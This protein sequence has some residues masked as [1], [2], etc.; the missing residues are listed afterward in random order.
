LALLLSLLLVNG[1]SATSRRQATTPAPAHCPSRFRVGF[2]TDVAGLN[3][4]VDAEG[5]AGTQGA[6]GRRACLQVELL[7]PSDPGSYQAALEL[8][9]DRDDLVI[10]GSF[11]LTDAVTAAAAD[12]PTAWFALVDPLVVP[13]ARHN[14]AVISFREDQAGFLAGA[15]A[16]MVSRTRVLAGVYGP[17]GGAISR[18]RHGFELGAVNV[19]PGITVLGAYQPA[20]DGRP[21]GNADW[22]KQEAANLLGRGADV[23]F[24]AG[25]VTGEGALAAAAQSRRFCIG[26]GGDQFLSVPAAQACLLTSAV[27]HPDRAVEAEILLA[28]DSQWSG[29]SSIFGI[30]EGAVGLA[31]FHMFDSEIT[32]AMRTRLAALQDKLLAGQFLEGN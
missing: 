9:A 21:F 30:R 3:S 8:L 4:S 17:E 28:A 27:T 10:A 25:G 20:G 24:G 22:G 11:L 32:K 5:W 16:A 19:D 14:L 26:A 29:G 12:R 13:A 2:V 15:L 23:V 1:G 6:A 31:P 18:Y 7:Q